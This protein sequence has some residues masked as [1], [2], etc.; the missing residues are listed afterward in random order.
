MYR[1]SLLS[2]LSPTLLICCVFVNGHSERCE[3]TSHGGMICISLIISDVKH[4][5]KCL[6]ALCMSSLEKYLLKSSVLFFFSAFFFFR[7]TPTALKKNM[8]VPRPWVK[9]ELQLPAYRTA[10]AMQDLSCICDLHHSQIP[11]PLSRAGIKPASSWILV[12]F[13]STSPQLGLPCPCLNQVVCFLMLNYKSS[14][15]ILYINLL[16]RYND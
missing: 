4:L 14:F 11:G 5:V 9:L 2:T 1:G 3:M 12:R 16:I 6:L 15:Y 10:T 13:V 8:E 7:A